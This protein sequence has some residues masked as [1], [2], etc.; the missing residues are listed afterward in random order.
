ME[1]AEEPLRDIE[2]KIETMRDP[3]HVKNRSQGDFLALY[4]KYG[5]TVTKQES[6]RVPVLLSA[7]LALTDT[8]D[9][10]RREIEALMKDEMRNGVHTG[11]CPYIEN[12]EIYFEQRW[13][14]F[15]GE[16][17]DAD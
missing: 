7:W 8:S 6:I 10:I 4:E 16:K 1:A 17:T 9:D 15:I 14:L 13:L 3:S 5:Y 2:D 11:L 12:G